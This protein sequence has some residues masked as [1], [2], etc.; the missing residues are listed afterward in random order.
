MDRTEKKVLLIQSRIN[1]IKKEN[2]QKEII[3]EM[4]K[5]GIEELPYSYS[6][7]KK[8]IDSETMSIHYN[9]HYKGY[10]DKL[11]AALSKRK[12]GDKDLEKIIRNISNYS[13][14]VRNNAGGA[15]NHA[16]FWNML[17]PT[18][19]KLKGE[20]LKKI[21]KEYGNFINFKK[22]FETVAKDR[23]GSGWV[24]LVVGK[25]NK[26]KIVST[27]NQDNPLMNVVKDG[28]FPIL[29]LDLW[30]H[31]YYLKYRN[32]RDE[33]IINFWKVVNWDFVSKLYEMKSETSLLENIKEKDVLVEQT[34]SWFID[35]CSTEDQ[36]FFQQ[37]MQDEKIKAEYGKGIYRALGNVPWLEFRA[38]DK[39]QNRMKGFYK[40]GV[41]HKL[42]ML[43]GNYRA[44]CMIAKSINS[45]LKQTGRQELDFEKDPLHAVNELIKILTK[46]APKFF[47]ESSKFYAALMK[48]LGDSKEKGDN[49]EDLT[50]TRLEKKFG[51][52]N[53]TIKSEF[54]SQ[55]D[56][57]GLD[58]IVTIDGISKSMQIKPFTKKEN[59]EDKVIIETTAMIIDY[60][61]DLM[62]FTNNFETLVFKNEEMEKGAHSYTFPSKNLIYTLR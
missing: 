56:N 7:L 24:W 9:K 55:S 8:F 4:K 18:P 45:G 23:F 3:S 11:N 29:G 57:K 53:V 13:K 31:A 10:V 58:G 43:A 27:P 61:Q 14:Q 47:D 59:K 36:R 60:V 49:V 38:M 2:E 41:R 52:K 25:N 50:K 44:F 22:E 32:K 6:A 39:T 40:D 12:G 42:S 19:K 30:E 16:L 26:L 33:Y 46:N 51:Q 1:E 15:F 54:G 48:N 21:N 5:I 28:G 37:M 34:N 17:T 35:A 20:L 62:V